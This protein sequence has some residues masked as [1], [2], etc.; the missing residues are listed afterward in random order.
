M[1][2]REAESFEGGGGEGI[3]FL[4][5]LRRT[6]RAVVARSG[7]CQAESPGGG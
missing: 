5:G 4:M 7:A 3:G 1:G 2:A 6:E